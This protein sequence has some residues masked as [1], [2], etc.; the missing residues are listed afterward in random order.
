MMDGAAYRRFYAD[1]I[2]AVAN[3]ASPGV[4]EALAEVPREQFLPPGP[5]TIR[6]EG[7][8]QG[9]PRQTPDAD[10]RHIHH[11][12]AVAIDAGRMLFN[13]APSVVAMAIDQLR[14]SPGER[15]LHLGTGLGYYTA[16]LARCVGPSGRVL[17][18]EVDEALARRAGDNLRDL[19]WAEVRQGDG[20]QP[21]DEPFDAVLVNAGVTHPLA[22][23][24]DALSPGGR[25]IL[26]LT[27]AMGPAPIGKGPMVLLTRTEE[28]RRLTARI[29]GFVAIYSALGL[30]DEAT[31]ALIAAALTKAPFAPVKSARLDSHDIGPSCWVHAPG[32]CVSL[33]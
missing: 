12:V 14:L 1:E 24:L 19:A 31:N 29:V 28:P 7:D 8:F 6:G 17:G 22:A 33:D 27:A 4:V 20:R 2:R 5:W 13:G 18:I 9:P 16:I 32:F 23:W 15:V 26:P 11:N 25:L 21:L 30:R 10:P 3:I